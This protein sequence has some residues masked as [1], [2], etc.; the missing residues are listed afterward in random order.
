[1]IPISYNVRSLL[2]RRTTTLAAVVGIALVV[3]VFAASLMLAEGVKKT[4]GNSGNPDRAVV[5]RKGSDGELSSTLEVATLSLIG[6]APG[7]LDVMLEAKAK[8]VALLWLR[9]QLRT[10]APAVAALEDR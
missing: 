2:V 1:M 3:F 5:M 9:R 10:L 6:A 8:D 7:P 4:L